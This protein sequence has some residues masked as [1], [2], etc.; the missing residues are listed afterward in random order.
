MTHFNSVDQN[1]SAT[2]A[3]A[4]T[5]VPTLQLNS[6]N[7]YIFF[8]RYFQILTI[9][10]YLSTYTI[11]V[12][13]NLVIT[14]NERSYVGIDKTDNNE[15]IAVLWVNGQSVFSRPFKNTA[16]EFTALVKFISE[17]CHRPKICLNPVHPSAFALV[18]YLGQIPEVEVVLMSNAGLKL[19]LDWLP[20]QLTQTDSLFQTHTN[21]AYLLAC[22]A[23]RMI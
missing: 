17:R 14:M 5:A 10:L 15:W 4:Q 7:F 20:K 23:E 11:S 21:R 12:F 1:P 2:P 18:G 3:W 6:Y 13:N 9:I 19:H 22:C 8:I 16:T